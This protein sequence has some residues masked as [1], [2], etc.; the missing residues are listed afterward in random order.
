MPPSRVKGVCATIE[1]R[2]QMRS[3]VIERYLEIKSQIASGSS[4]SKTVPANGGV[5][6]YALFSSRWSRLCNTELIVF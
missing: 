5:Q 2:Q 4:H 3:C 1:L 6:K